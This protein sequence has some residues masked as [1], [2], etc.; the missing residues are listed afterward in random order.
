MNNI[1][2]AGLSLVSRY[3]YP[4]NS[5]S[6]CGPEKQKNLQWYAANQ[7]PDKGTAEII[8][9]FSTLYP[10]L[11]LIASENK[12]PDPFDKQ[13]VEAYWVGNT[14]LSR[15]P[16]R[17]FVRHLEEPITLAKKEKHIIRERIYDKIASGALPHHS[18]HVLNIYKRTG[19]MD[20]PH[21]LETMD[22]CL[23]NWGQIKKIL[24]QTLIVETAPLIMNNNRLRFGP[25]KERTI[26]SQGE[27][28]VLFAKLK[29][30]DFVSYHWGYFCQT[31]TPS[32]LRNLTYYTK[33]SLQFANSN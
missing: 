1:D 20:I 27:K 14:L 3:S 32:Q 8:S 18:F 25:K 33:L 17:S 2:F 28:D 21:T 19:N 11:V 31:L 12:I 9:G 15:I 5:L 29:I 16:I 7:K 6:L 30:G 10:Y 22:A 13:V 23:I 26:I 4:P 24:P